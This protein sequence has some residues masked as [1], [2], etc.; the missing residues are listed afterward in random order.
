MLEVFTHGDGLRREG[1][2]A[3]EIFT[4]NLSLCLLLHETSNYVSS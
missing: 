4:L 1:D 2:S 3:G